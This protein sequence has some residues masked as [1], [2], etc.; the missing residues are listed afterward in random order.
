MFLAHVNDIV[1]NLKKPLAQYQFKKTLINNGQFKLV[2]NV[3]PHQKSL[4]ISKTQETL[5][6][7]YHGWSWDDNGVPSSNGTTSICNDFQLVMRDVHISNSL[8]FSEKINLLSL[9]LDLSYMRLVEERIDMINTCYRNIIDV[10]LDVDHI[11]VVHPDL[12]TK[13]G[14]ANSVKV[15]WEYYD[16]GNIQLVQKNTSY[17]KSFEKTL[18]GLREEKLSAV[19][20]TVYP[21]TT[22][23]WQ[24]GCL[25]I[26]VCVPVNDNLTKTI[27]Y[28]YRDTRYSDLNWKINSDI[29]ETA[30]QQDTAQAE[31][32][33]S[34]A[35]IDLHL[36]PAKKYFR[37]WERVNGKI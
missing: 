29:W 23:D 3:C 6:C 21:Y 9:P 19:W 10:F 34:N 30:W 35:I 7:R 24:P 20:I 28:K 4:I 1:P 37:N 16:W 18:L 14:V 33:V 26:V 11:S 15:E 12:Y 27:I 32:I 31:C 5:Q 8:I 25:T 2:N 22:I 13:V 17:D 36:E